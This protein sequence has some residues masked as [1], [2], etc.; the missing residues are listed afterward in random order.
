MAR[1]WRV[2][3]EARI[4]YLPFQAV[5]RFGDVTAAELDT[6]SEF[7]E[8]REYDWDRQ[9]SRSQDRCWVTSLRGAKELASYLTY[10]GF[11]VFGADEVYEL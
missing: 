1:D 5:V 10:K 6:V 9:I 8:S 7:M 11:K 3:P 4:E 2:P